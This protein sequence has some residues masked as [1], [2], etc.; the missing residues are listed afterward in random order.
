MEPK[1]VNRFQRSF[2]VEKELYLYLHIT[3]PPMLISLIILGVTA[4]VNLIVCLVCGLTYANL[5]VFAMCFIVLCIILYR[6]YAAIQ[7]GRSRLKEETNNKGEITVTASLDGDELISESTAREEPVYVPFSQLKKVFVTKNFYMIQ[8][9]EKMVYVFKKGAFSVGK[10][11][12]FLPYVRQ[13]IE[14]NK[15]KGK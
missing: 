5:A 15:K 1:F 10:E 6:Y 8:T 3:A 12:D 13:L 9:E 4:V 7:A 14:H 11:E 2:D